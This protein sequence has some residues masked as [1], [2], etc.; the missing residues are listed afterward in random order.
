MEISTVKETFDLL[1]KANASPYILVPELAKELKI[2]KT[3]L[4]KYIIENTKLFYTETCYSYKTK[5]FI[6]SFAGRKYRDEKQV[7]NRNLGMGILNVYLLPEDNYRTDEWLISQIKG[8]AKYFHISEYDN[9]GYI[10]GYYIAYDTD[11]QDEFRRYK[12][13]NTADKVNDLQKRFKLRKAAY[14]IGGFGDSSLCEPNGFEITLDQINELKKE[15]YTFNDF[16]P[17]TQ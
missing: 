10:G 11:T 7:K 4:T 15:G 3:V 5:K 14:Y 8:K 17:L 16:K 2:T 6:S 9:Y 13:R 12:W 1:R